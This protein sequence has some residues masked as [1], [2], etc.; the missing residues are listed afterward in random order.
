[1]GSHSINLAIRFLLEVSA[2]YCP[3][4]SALTFVNLLQ[5]NCLTME[6]KFFDMFNCLYTIL[7][8]W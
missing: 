6:S 1:M 4:E 7:Q 2:H 3:V 8:I 5:I